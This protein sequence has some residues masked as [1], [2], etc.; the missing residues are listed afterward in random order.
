MLR[1]LSSLAPKGLPSLLFTKIGES[2]DDVESSVYLSLNYSPPLNF[3]AVTAP[4]GR[5]EEYDIVVR[6]VKTILRGWSSL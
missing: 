1:W 4:D 2:N 3:V 6:V 5:T